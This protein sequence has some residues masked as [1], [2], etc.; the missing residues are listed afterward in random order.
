[1]PVNKAFSWR[2]KVKADIKVHWR[3]WM[4]REKFELTYDDYAQSANTLFHFMTKFEY[5]EDILL[6]NAIVPRYC[7]EDLEYLK[8]CN[9]GA[10]FSEIYVLQK[11]FCDI[12]FHKL[13]E[14]FQLQP[15]GENYQQLSETE[16]L[17]VPTDYSHPDY[18]GK[19]AIAF[20]KRWGERNNL[21]PIH[22]LNEKS[23]YTEDLSN[24]VN[25]ILSADDV[26]DVFSDDILNRLCFIKP[27]RG[28]MKRKFEREDGSQIEIEFYKNFHD[29]QEWRYVPT[30]AET[31]S[32]KK[33]TVIANPHL[34][35]M[36]GRGMEI[37]DGLKDDLCKGLWLNY[38][39]DEIRYIIVPDSN[40]RI[41]IIN[42]IMSIPEE[43]FSA[44]SDV[45]I[46]KQILI[47]KILVLEEIRKDW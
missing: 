45:T 32:V 1:M 34:L 19:Y 31:T 5:L 26:P 21:Q 28:I 20:S 17:R 13:T 43:K 6:R 39:Y 7:K 37:N 11:C 12:P 46:Q 47:S 8:I 9:E 44:Q 14:H 3:R 23:Q 2:F 36:N 27:L 33:D 22:Y 29:E 24:L 18:Y 10:S 41:R 42:T 30:I 38:S 16:K 35:Q 15:T 25:Q 4:S 40:E